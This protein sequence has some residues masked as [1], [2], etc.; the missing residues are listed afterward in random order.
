MCTSRKRYIGSTKFT[1]VYAAELQGIEMALEIAST[2]ISQG[3]IRFFMFTDNQAALRA[4]IHPG[5]HSGQQIL[6][7]VILKLLKLWGAGV[8]FDFH[9]IPAH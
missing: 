7:S 2:A 9:W 4:L 6:A 5:D 3:I 8:S 1:T